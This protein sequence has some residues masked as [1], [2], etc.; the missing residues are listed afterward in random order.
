MARPDKIRTISQLEERINFWCAEK[1]LRYSFDDFKQNREDGISITS[2]AKS[3]HT[4]YAT[5]DKWI[6]IYEHQKASVS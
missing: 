3:F 5:M 4:S 1:K 2:M 6:R